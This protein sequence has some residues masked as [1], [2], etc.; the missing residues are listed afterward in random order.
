M[1]GFARWI[2]DSLR[3]RIA[4]VVSMLAFALGV[5]VLFVSYFEVLRV[6][7]DLQ[8]GRLRQLGEQLAPL[9]ARAPAELLTRLARAAADSAVVAF[10]ASGAQRDRQRVTAALRS[11]PAD[12]R[13]M[14]A[15]L[16]TAG[17]PLLH[18]GPDSQ[19]AW[20]GPPLDPADLAPQEQPR[21][22]PHRWLNDSTLY[23]DAHAPVRLNGAII[24]TVVRRT[25]MVL[26]SQSRSTFDVILGSG[27]N[28][29]LGSP[30]TG[31]WTD[32]GAVIPAPPASELRTGAVT[33]FR[34]QGKEALALAVPIGGTPWLLAV[35]TD[36]AVV[37]APARA[38]LGRAALIAAL[39]VTLGTLGGVALGRTLGQPIESITQVTEQIAT[40]DDPRRVD[41]TAPGEVGRLGRAFNAMVE[42]LAAST[43]RLR[44]NEAS[45]RAFVAHA[46]EGIWRIEFVPPIATGL[47]RELQIAS[48]YRMAPLAEC[49]A[50]LARMHGAEPTG[51]L[52][53]IPLAQ[54]FPPDDPETRELLTAFIENGYRASE[55]ESRL[56]RSGE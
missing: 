23:Y 8:A 36:Y 9:L 56:T 30:A 1:G 18:A 45:H 32:L 28:L 55:C 50:A 6:T 33:R 26:S 12:Q 51:E 7:R 46:S 37:A 38:Y 15:L 29:V 43:R 4:A 25:R 53:T 48:W 54:L 47:S 42:R 41:E 16:D 13:S 34:W 2:N 24:G 40:A 17:K 39:V 52:G 5:G 27:T 19:Q 20:L 35:R 44:D 3:R 31:V 49:N 14:V 22:G 10:V 21:V 11:A